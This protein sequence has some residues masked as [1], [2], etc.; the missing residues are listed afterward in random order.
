M[1]EENSSG[2]IEG[3]IN[4]TTHMAWL[5]WPFRDLSNVAAEFPGY[6]ATHHTIEVPPASDDKGSSVGVWVLEHPAP[7]L[8]VMYSHGQHET[9]GKAH[10]KTLCKFL[11]DQVCATVI[12]YDPRGYGDSTDTAGKGCTP[13]AAIRDGL[14]VL[15]WW[16]ARDTRALPVILWGHS[17]GGAQAA[18]M[19]RSSPSVRGL[20]LQATFPSLPE[21]ASDHFFSIP[22]WTL[23]R[24]RRLSLIQGWVATAFK[25]NVFRFDTSDIVQRLPPTLPVLVLHGNKDMVLPHAYL[26]RLEKAA[27]SPERGPNA[28]PPRSCLVHGADHVMLASTFGGEILGVLVP[29]LQEDVSVPLDRSV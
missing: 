12:S 8:V 2:Y 6:N 14:A 22:L 10:R 13:D 23:P 17:L 28:V 15:R 25:G 29:W 24:E 27:A 7:R 26:A 16:Q 9:R 11:H 4:N 5:K 1:A 3:F 18:E 21:A 19:A 20:V